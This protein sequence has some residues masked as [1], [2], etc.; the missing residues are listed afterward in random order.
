L[1]YIS[2]R[3]IDR[4]KPTVVG[5]TSV[6]DYERYLDY[7]LNYHEEMLNFHVALARL[8]ELTGRMEP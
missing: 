5:W 3:I 8:E 2:D 4:I 6:K 1:L 7:E